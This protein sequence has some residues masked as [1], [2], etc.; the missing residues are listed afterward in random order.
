MNPTHFRDDEKL[1]NETFANSKQQRIVEITCQP[2]SL[3][4]ENSQLH[5]QHFAAL[6]I[7]LVYKCFNWSMKSKLRFHEMLQKSSI[8]SEEL[9]WSQKAA[10]LQTL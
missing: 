5:F 7:P 3:Y 4:S 8:I 10:F 6:C 9:D 1:H 2:S